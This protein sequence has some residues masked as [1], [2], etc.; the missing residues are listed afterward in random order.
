[1]IIGS[2]AVALGGVSLFISST[3]GQNQTQA[4]SAGEGDIIVE[5]RTAMSRTA[6]TIHPGQVKHQLLPVL[7]VREDG[8]VWSGTIT[9]TA[10]KPIEV[11]IVQKYSPDQQANATHGEPFHGIA[12]LLNNTD[13]AFTILKDAVDT[14]LLVNGTTISSGT[15]DFAGSALALHQSEGEPFTATYTVDAVAKDLVPLN[16]SASE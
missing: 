5:Q 2:I 15:F 3:Y 12:V 11:E 16:R 4:D 7:P 10:S 9:F 13:V 6:V 1:M 8:K 14:H